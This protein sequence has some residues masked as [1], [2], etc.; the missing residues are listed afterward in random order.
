MCLWEMQC[1]RMLLSKVSPQHIM[2]T[3]LSRQDARPQH[4]E[5]LPSDMC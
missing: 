3:Q 2:H 5:G 1:C 4:A